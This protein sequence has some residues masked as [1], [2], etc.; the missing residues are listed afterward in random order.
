MAGIKWSSSEV[1]ILY[2]KY[3][4]LGICNEI[5][6]YLPNRTLMAIG[7]KACSLKIKCL[8]SNQK[9]SETHLGKLNTNWKGENI[10]ISTGNWRATRMY[11]CPVLK[12]MK[13]ERH[14]LDRN[15]KNNNPENIR[16]V[17]RRDHMTIDGRL[18]KPRYF[19]KR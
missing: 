12:W 4:Q 9:I 16:F 1:D 11:R 18:T 10:V 8:V 15:P 7:L 2:E 17:T 19:K 6:S 13:L 14:H 5:K 3:P